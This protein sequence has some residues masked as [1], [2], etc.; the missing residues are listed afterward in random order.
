MDLRTLRAFVEVVKQGGFSAAAETIHAS[1]PTIS[2]A[3]RQL[4]DEL[5]G[6][7]LERLGHQVRMTAM[8]E[9]VYRRA[10][11]MLAERETLVAELA[12]LRGL[13]RG[14]L[15]IGIPQL[16]SSIIFAPL[17]TQYRL[18]YPE[19][20]IDL[21][22]RGSVPLKDALRSGA[23]D[24]AAA[25]E[26]IEEEFDRLSMRDEPMMV[27]LPPN[28]PL[29]GRKAI[30][31]A[32]LAD[33]NFILFEAGF[34]LNELIHEACRRHGFVPRAAARSSQPDFIT[35]LVATGLGI[36]LLPRLVVEG[37]QDLPVQVA[38]LDEPDV[39]WRLS[40]IWRRGAMLAPAAQAWLDLT[41][42]QSP[43][44]GSNSKR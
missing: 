7:L 31:L 8:G 3:V 16:G 18:R 40:L 22:E 28:H 39:R 21:A 1:Q 5:G 42:G 44:R 12:E 6:A 14:R 15:R 19:I 34:T 27:L 30:K 24:L 29:S 23:L 10:Q 33:D 38:L 9:L 20:E 37:R 17:V 36:A 4:E 35:V 43:G 41:R 25:I 13:K 2:K 32:E 26:P 11:V